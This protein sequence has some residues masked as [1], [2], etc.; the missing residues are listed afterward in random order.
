MGPGYETFRLFKLGHY[1]THARKLLRDISMMQ[2]PVVS[3][4]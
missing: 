1:V 4:H 3:I 2:L